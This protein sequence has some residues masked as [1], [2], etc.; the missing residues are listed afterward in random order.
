MNASD[1]EQ[2]TAHPIYVRLVG[3]GFWK[4]KIPVLGSDIAGW[5]EAV[6]SNVTHV[7][8]GRRVLADTLYHGLGGFAEYVS[9]P[10][11]APLVHKPESL[12]FEDAAAI[13]QACLYMD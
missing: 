11:S 2:L 8:A 13:P 10:E 3:F 4:P 9:I 12:T 6:G 5:V 7:S 1:V